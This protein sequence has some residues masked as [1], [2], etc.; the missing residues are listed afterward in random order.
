VA[1][2]I[3]QEIK[4]VPGT[5]DVYTVGAPRQAV[6]VLLDPQA[7]AGHG[8]DLTKIESRPLVGK[9]WDYY[10]Y[11]DFAGSAADEPVRAALA[12]LEKIAPML[13]LLGS[14]P[15]ARPVELS[16]PPGAL[17]DRPINASR[18]P[19]NFGA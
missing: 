15:R 1:H 17:N 13:R 7:L 6:R 18:P 9:P 3:E 12:R 16:A 5:K 4:R 10:F 19:H 14:Y 2:A 11:L 8:I